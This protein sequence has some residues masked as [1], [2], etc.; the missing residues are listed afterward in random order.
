VKTYFKGVRKMKTNNHFEKTKITFIVVGLVAAIVLAT[1]RSARAATWT[2]KAD[3]PTP[4]QGHG[5]AVVNGKIYVIG[6]LTSETGFLATEGVSAVEEYDPATDTWT[7]KADMPAARG[8]LPGSHPVVDGK[9][10][11]IGGGNPPVARVDVY[12]PGT[13]TWSRGVDMPTPRL[14]FPRVAWNGKIYTF[15][16]LSGLRN[17]DR[18]LKTTDV[19]DPKKN[20]W[21][22]AT[23]MPQGVWQ[24]SANEVDGKIYVV[25]GAFHIDAMQIHQVY[26][27]QTNTWTNATP[28]PIRTRG[29]TTSVVCGKIYA[30]GGWLN[31][32]QRPRSDTWVYDPTTDMWTETAPLPDVRAGFT[33]CVVNGRIYAIGGTPNGHPTRATSTVYELELDSRS[34]DLNGDG[35]VDVADIS[36]LVDHWH[37]DNPLY[38]IAPAPCGDGIIDIQDMIVLSE[39]LLPVFAAHWELDE[40]E[41]SVAYDRIGDNDSTL[42]GNPF[43]QPSGGMIGGTLLF[44]GIDDY[45][46]T[47]FILNPAE[48]SFSVFAWIYGWTPGQVI[49][50]QTGDFGGTWLGTNPSDGKLMTGFSD[51][52]FG[53]LESES[54]VTDIQWHHVGFV[55]DMDSF[56]RRLYVDGILIAEDTTAVS[57]VPSDSGLFIGASKDLDAGTFFSG[58]IDDVRIYNKALTAEEI[59]ALAR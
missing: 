12:D 15:G 45:V 49:I 39:H 51:I 14:I 58:F 8:Y 38:D 50:S 1:V 52:N 4:R 11:V 37:M 27:P 55:Y 7:R 36:I 16:G 41:G 29:H 42:N 23:T 57:G 2:Q 5:S 25:G 24:H 17:S 18:G 31:S 35:V 53:A 40:T 47:P 43:W 59:E 33:A 56:H 6:G 9:I 26:D 46:S 34:P 22:E 30:V 21:T 3:M 13:D 54:V 44:D 20:T 28:M 19:Y 10:Y 48:G 32:G